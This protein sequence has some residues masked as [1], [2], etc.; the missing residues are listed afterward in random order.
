MADSSDDHQMEIRCDA[1]LPGVN[2][3]PTTGC[4]GKGVNAPEQHPT[5]FIPRL[6][7]KPRALLL[8]RTFISKLLVTLSMALPLTL[9]RKKKGLY[10]RFFNRKLERAD[11]EAPFDLVTFTIRY[12]TLL[13]TLLSLAPSVSQQA[14]HATG[15]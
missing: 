12:P 15:N 1:A 3:G 13:V 4:A 11:G 10:R 14:D 2:A 6:S 7:S 9:S 8:C 5:C